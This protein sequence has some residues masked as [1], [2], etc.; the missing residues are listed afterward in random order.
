MRRIACT[1]SLSIFLFAVTLM[2]ANAAGPGL[3]FVSVNAAADSSGVSITINQ[4][5][6]RNDDTSQQSTSITVLSASTD[7]TLVC[8][9]SPSNARVEIRRNGA[10][11]VI[12]SVDAQ[13]NVTF[14][15]PSI[16]VAGIVSN[17]SCESP[18]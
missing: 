6:E 7:Q 17:F 9:Y 11:D 16:R 1:A 10:I 2:T 4:S 3:N 14:T 8:T 18:D 15:A 5:S 13:T 12:W